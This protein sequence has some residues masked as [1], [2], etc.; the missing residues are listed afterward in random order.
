[1]RKGAAKCESCQYWLKTHSYPLC[2]LTDNCPNYRSKKKVN[3]GKCPLFRRKKINKEPLYSK[4]EL[5]NI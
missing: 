1:M 2:D 5:D 3:A 4:E